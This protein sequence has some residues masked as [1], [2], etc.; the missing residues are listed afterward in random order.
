MALVN[1]YS[2]LVEIAKQHYVAVDEDDGVLK[3]TG[4]VANEEIKNKIWEVYNQL[5][6]HFKSGEVVMNIKV[7]SR[8]GSKVKV[9]TQSGNLN[10]RKTPS[11]YHEVVGSAAN[12]EILTLLNKVNDYWWYIRNDEGVEGY[13]YVQYLEALD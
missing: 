1:K 6:P 9:V 5:D 12:G 11:T 8:E 13:C 4:E 7:K 10:I 2:A 3:I